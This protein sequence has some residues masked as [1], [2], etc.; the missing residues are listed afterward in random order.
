[1][2]TVSTAC[3]EGGVQPRAASPHQVESALPAG[4][5]Q[6]R[7]SGWQ[8]SGATAA[9]AGT[10]QVGLH[11]CAVHVCMAP[12][13]RLSISPDMESCYRRLPDTLLSS[14][15]CCWFALATELYSRIFSTLSPAGW[16]GRSRDRGCRGCS[17]RAARR[18]HKPQG[19][20]RPGKCQG[21]GNWQQGRRG[22]RCVGL[23]L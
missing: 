8:C 6:V 2:V 14:L 5:N 23:G 13:A 22:R 7:E 18:G 17:A 3:Q 15:S 1:M 16:R 20:S 11:R 21:A 4:S 9:F 19:V 12:S 10:A